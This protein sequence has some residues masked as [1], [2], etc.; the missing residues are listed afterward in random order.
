MGTPLFALNAGRFEV[1][2]AETAG[3]EV[4]N[5][6]I[7][8]KGKPGVNIS[9]DEFIALNPSIIMVSGFLSA[10]APDYLRT[11]R[12]KGL[13]VDAVQNGAVFTMP[14]GWD[15]GSPRW[16]LGLLALARTLHP[17]RCPFDLEA[18]TGRF[19][20]DFYGRDPETVMRNRSFTLPSS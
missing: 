4:V 2:L 3:G 14:P 15:F 8:R 7:P 1:S 6:S 16:A 5:R 20:Q 12:E 11:C 10:P 19:Y 9:A 17:D 13:M 18:E